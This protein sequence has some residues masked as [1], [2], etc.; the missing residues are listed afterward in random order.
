MNP[1]SSEL[2]GQFKVEWRKPCVTGRAFRKTKYQ[3]VGHSNGGKLCHLQSTLLKCGVCK[4]WQEGHAE[5]TRNFLESSKVHH[6]DFGHCQRNRNGTYLVIFT[7]NVVMI[8]MGNSHDTNYTRCMRM[9]TTMRCLQSTL[10][11]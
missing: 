10:M 2:H 8:C 5:N 7:I 11:L 1:L 6:P 9:D 4:V 3:S